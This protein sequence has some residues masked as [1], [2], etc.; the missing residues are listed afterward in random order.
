[1]NRMRLSKDLA[2]GARHGLFKEG[3]RLPA[4]GP[5][6][7]QARPGGG[8]DKDDANRPPL[9]ATAKFT[10]PSL[11][12]D[13]LSRPRLISQIDAA[14]LGQIVL[15]NAPAGYGKTRLLT[16]WASR[17][18]NQTAW[19]T[20]DDEDND[21]HRFWA[22]IVAALCA[23]PA[24][25][26][27]S[28]LHLIGQR[29]FSSHNPSFLAIVVDALAALKVPFSL[30]LD[31]VHELVSAD[32]LHG[33]AALVRDWPAKLRL[34][35]ATRAEPAL[36]FSRLRLAGRLFELRRPAL[37]LSPDEASALVNLSA[38]PL[39]DF[40]RGFLLKQADGWPACL[41]LAT[42]TMAGG[43][44]PIST[45]LDLDGDGGII[46]DYFETEVLLWLPDE[47]RALLDACSICDHLPVGLAA[48]LSGRQDAGKLL[49]WT[50]RQLQLIVVEKDRGRSF[51]FHPMLQSH[52]ITEIEQ[53]RPE[54]LALLHA[55]ASQWFDNA[56][57]PE[58]AVRHAVYAHNDEW[59]VGLLA[60]AAPQLIA[61]GRD[62]LVKSALDSL[63]Q[64]RV[65]SDPWL[66]LSAA[67]VCLGIGDL[68][69]S[70]AHLARVTLPSEP[71]TD[72][73]WFRA[74]VQARRAWLGNDDMSD[75]LRQIEQY[76]SD[77]SAL[78]SLTG[79]TS[80][81]AQIHD[82]LAIV[83]ARLPDLTRN[84]EVEVTGEQRFSTQDRY[85]IAHDLASL[86]FKAAI[87]GNLRQMTAHIEQIDHLDISED[88]RP[89]EE[90]AL[91]AVMR[92]YGMLMR[93]QPGECL[94]LAALAPELE[95]ASAAPILLSTINITKAAARFD[96][97]ERREG[98]E[99]LRTARLAMGC[100]SAMVENVATVTLFEFRAATLLGR[101]N[102][103]R[104]VLEWAESQL[105][106][107]GEV[108]LM[109]AFS[110]VR[111]GRYI[112][113]RNHLRPLLDGSVPPVLN[114]TSAEGWLLQC[115]IALN[116][117]NQKGAGQAL[118][119]ALAIFAQ[120]GVIRPMMTAPQEVFDLLI[121]RLG[122]LGPLETFGRE[123]LGAKVEYVHELPTALTEREWAILSTLPS[124]RTLEEIGRDLTISINTVKSHVKAIYAKLN[125]NTRRAA[126]AAAYRK[127]L[128]S[129]LGDPDLGAA[130][131][132][133]A[134]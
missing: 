72:L 36:H 64:E 44:S 60:R 105:G 121:R 63:P 104:E 73:V 130:A 41:Q 49:T 67:M 51:R 45:S 102:S 23:C 80:A 74:L 37:A 109:R 12:Y 54:H 31:N 82:S 50:A 47:V 76:A 52:L 88:S 10:L 127:G 90:R 101:T 70:D 9:I 111:I 133:G 132:S 7:A 3:S 112:A 113:A 85:R 4:I 35:L 43:Q 131:N 22:G 89:A 2:V 108:L 34:I 39:D 40:R 38:Q 27:T 57:E 19:V 11:P 106:P 95:N 96:I 86:A 65:A 129:N 33:L 119:S 71:S 98:F 100:H 83:R 29:D 75:A 134:C 68:R 92:A 42:H 87:T 115:E 1:M 69:G 16:E 46:G 122:S 77:R 91:V 123:V 79:L 84:C 32:A 107:V 110:S 26:R 8:A 55:R 120:A 124:Q 17:H 117:G 30:V 15:I 5:L 81:I 62:E 53:E 78:S 99:S 128:I 126:V 125:V 56:H 114:W 118:E 25:P 13:H 66:T 6:A 18:P 61:A 24:V 116:A 14:P 58:P 97:G 94:R 59:M 20:L 93:A 21:D 28:R 103:A 48:A